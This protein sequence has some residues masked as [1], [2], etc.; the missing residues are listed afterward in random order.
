MVFKR[1]FTWQLVMVI[2]I[3]AVSWS[4]AWQDTGVRPSSSS[5][6]RRSPIKVE[7][8][9]MTTESSPPGNLVALH[10]KE[11][12]AAGMNGA[13]VIER[14]PGRPQT[15]NDGNTSKA[16]NLSGDTQV[17]G[18]DLYAI[19]HP[20]TMMLLGIACIG[21]AAFRRRRIIRR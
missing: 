11:W 1:L 17:H 5:H 14:S 20:S 16:N 2:S 6:S 15:R 3:C 12:P 7:A 18:M 8:S 21:M 19:P 4:W 13:V 10:H 9:Q